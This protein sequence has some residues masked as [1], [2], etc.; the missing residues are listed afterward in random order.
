MKNF[1]RMIACLVIFASGFMIGCAD[2]TSEASD[3]VAFSKFSMEHVDTDLV[4]WVGDFYLYADKETGVEY[5]VIQNS[6]NGI[7]I[8]PRYKADGSLY[9]KEGK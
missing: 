3:K 6:E 9:V 4:N 7:G 8:T 2:T 1:K 5:I